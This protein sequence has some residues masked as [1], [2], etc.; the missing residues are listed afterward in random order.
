MKGSIL[1]GE[2]ATRLRPMALVVSKQLL[3]RGGECR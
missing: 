2:S 1:V 3:L